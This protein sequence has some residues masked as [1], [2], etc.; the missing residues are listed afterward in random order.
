MNLLLTLATAKSILVP[1]SLMVINV[2]GQPCCTKTL[3][4]NGVFQFIMPIII[5]YDEIIVQPC[6]PN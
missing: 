2:R 3:G 5:K 6:G 4:G 1:L